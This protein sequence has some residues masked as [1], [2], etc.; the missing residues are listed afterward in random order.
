MSSLARHLC[1][2]RSSSSSG[3]RRTSHTAHVIE[4]TKPE[5]SETEIDL[6]VDEGINLQEKLWQT[7][8]GERAQ[9]FAY[10]QMKSLDSFTTATYET[11]L[12]TLRGMCKSHSLSRY[13]DRIEKVL[14]GLKPFVNA[15]NILVSS[16]PEVAGLVWGS[17]QLVLESALRYTSIFDDISQTIEDLAQ[18]LP[19]FGAFLNILRTPKLHAALREVYC[20]YIEF[21][22]VVIRFLRRNP[23]SRLHTSFRQ[24]LV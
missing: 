24:R 4:E 15:L 6:D 13:Q 17:T 12:K 22:A 8:V 5:S 11:S 14:N 9:S 10:S 20:I 23:W 19:R 7:A 1:C 2:F 18:I 16:H 3:S 21:Y